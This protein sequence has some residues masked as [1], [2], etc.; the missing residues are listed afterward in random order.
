MA[1]AT[2]GRDRTGRHVCGAAVRWSGE[3]RP[4]EVR[5]PTGCG[6][7]DGACGSTTVTNGHGRVSAN[8]TF[9][10]Q[11]E[12]GTVGS[13]ARRTTHG[14][15]SMR[16][17][18]GPAGSAEAEW[19]SGGYEAWPS[20]RFAQTRTRWPTST[21]VARLACGAY[22]GRGLWGFAARVRES[23]ACRI[24]GSCYGMVVFAAVDC[25]EHLRSPS[26]RLERS[27]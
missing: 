8:Q 7:V 19:Q 17:L 21:W 23:S 24:V 6:G 27:W 10:L 15:R 26:W 14:G 16:T 4:G 2:H 5:F 18:R 12:G 3:P 22:R 11:P 13:D 1:D 25:S 20:V 9:A